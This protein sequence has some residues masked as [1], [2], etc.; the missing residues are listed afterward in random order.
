VKARLADRLV[1]DMAVKVF[2]DQDKVWRAFDAPGAMPARHR[3]LVRVEV[4]L[5]RPAYSYLLMLTSQGE[6]VPLYPWNDGPKQPKGSADDPPPVRREQS[7]ANPRKAKTGWTMDRT[8]GLETL[9]LL[10]REEPLPAGMKL[11]RFVRE[12][13]AGEKAVLR[14]PREAAMLERR[15]GA[16]G[17]ASLLSLHRGIEEAR[18]A[19]APLA[20]MMDRLE[21]TFVVQRVARFAHAGE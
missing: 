10:V 8:P 12:M 6:V 9:L 5:D 14:N 13:L 4:K 19:D 20:E 3:D 15:R 1:A 18:E 11:G 2:S 7:W 21:E 16:K 17:Y